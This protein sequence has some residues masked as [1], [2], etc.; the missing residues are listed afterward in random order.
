[1]VAIRSPP[2]SPPGVCGPNCV[3]TRRGAQSLGKRW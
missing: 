2:A 1:L 3:M